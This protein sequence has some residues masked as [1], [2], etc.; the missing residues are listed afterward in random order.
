MIQT[1]VSASVT[2]RKE[3]AETIQPSSQQHAKNN[4]NSLKI[5]SLKFLQKE[6]RAS[7]RP[8]ETI[9]KHKGAFETRVSFKRSTRCAHYDKIERKDTH[10]PAQSTTSHASFS[11][12]PL[13]TSLSQAVTARPR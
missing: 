13:T 11:L 3:K 1:S 12:F 2:S 7:F 5:L 4:I 6:A 9:H 10:R 8:S